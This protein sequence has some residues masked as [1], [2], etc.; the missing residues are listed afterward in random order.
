MKYH[1]HGETYIPSGRKVTLCRCV[2]ATCAREAAEIALS[3]NKEKYEA[4]YGCGIVVTWPGGH[5]NFT[6]DPDNGH[7]IECGDSF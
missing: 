5:Q 6:I 3:K 7:L 1:V 2:N 4:L